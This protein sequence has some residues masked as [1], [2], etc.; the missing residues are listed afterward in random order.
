MTQW[1]Y[2]NIDN[3]RQGP[4]PADILL[5]KLK[6]GELN[7]QTLVWCEGMG[8]WQP[9]SQVQL[10]AGSEPDGQAGDAPAAGCNPDHADG[11]GPAVQGSAVR[12]DEAASPYVAPASPVSELDVAVVEGGEIVHAGFWK[13]VAANVI[14]SFVIGIVTTVIMLIMFPVLGI[15]LVGMRGA[16][17][18]FADNSEAL[19]VGFALI[20]LLQYLVSFVLTATYYIWLHASSRKATLGKMAVGIKVVRMSGERISVARSIGRY[21]AF[22]L[23]FITMGIGFIMAGLTQRKQALHDMICDTLVVDKW[24]FTDRPELQQRGLGAVTIVVLALYGLFLLAFAVL[25]LLVAGMMIYEGWRQ[26]GLP[27]LSAGL[28]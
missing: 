1:Y 15:G 28:A 20:H 9:I 12:S 17:E 11:H 6:R 13:R 27:G 25:G 26:A 24:A 2:V 21:F 3:Q 8:E 22:V 16:L 5:E 7:R 19:D 14:D 10:H 18:R 23:N 4:V